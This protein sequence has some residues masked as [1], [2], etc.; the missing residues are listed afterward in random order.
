MMLKKKTLLV[1]LALVV[2]FSACMKG[3]NYDKEA[4][5]KID[6]EAIQQ[7]ITANKLTDV[8]QSGDLFYQVIKEGTGTEVIKTSDKV[9]VNYEGKLLNG[10]VFD[11][12]TTTP[13][14]FV[15]GEVIEGWQAGV[16]LIKQGGTIRLLIPSTMAYR[17]RSTGAIPANSP[18]DF[19]ISVISVNKKT[20][21]QQ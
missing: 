16:P 13:V 5:L 8:K 2:S 20:E 19:T 21:N 11:K 6:T 14:S 17:N 18:L 1:M 9:E 4:Q 10:K 3:E 15:L 12:T 7:F